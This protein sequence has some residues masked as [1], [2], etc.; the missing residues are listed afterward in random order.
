MITMLTAAAMFIGV[1]GDP[2][3]TYSACLRDAV[4][5]AKIAKVAAEGFKAYAHETCAAAEETFKASRVAFNVKNGMGRKTA[6]EDAQVQ[7]DDYLFSA[8]DKY[9]FSLQPPKQAQAAISP[10]K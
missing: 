4:A 5:N 6:L 7:I 9:L 2:R 8:E 1:S 3:A 10:S